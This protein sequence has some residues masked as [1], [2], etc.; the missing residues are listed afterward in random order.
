MRK[1]LIVLFFLP[2]FVGAKSDSTKTL[3]L[4]RH[5]KSTDSMMTDFNRPLE[6]RGWD[7]AKLMAEWIK[8]ENH[9]PDLIIASPSVRTRQTVSV[10]CKS[11]GFDSTKIV[12][13]STI[14]RCTAEALKKSINSADNKAKTVMIVGHNPSITTVANDLQ[15]D[16]TFD[17]VPTTGFVMIN[18]K[19]TSWNAITKGKLKQFMSPGKL[20]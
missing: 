17:E 5:A 6:Q 14:Y 4:L 3:I 8:K 16:K 12:Y 11:T 18:F 9:L 15:N 7:D 2:L 1:L 10:F 13:D 19:E 20:K